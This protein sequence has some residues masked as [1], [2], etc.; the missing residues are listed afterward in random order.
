MSDT[1]TETASVTFERGYE[2]L[3]EIATRLNEDDVT[4]S[5]MCDLFAEGKGLEQALIQYLDTQQA[6]VQAIESGE[7]VRAFTITGA[8]S[9]PS[10]LQAQRSASVSKDIPVDTADF[11]PASVGAAAADDDI[12]F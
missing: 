10:A 4:V 3:Q 12:P 9:E 8:T 7:G 2:R 1:P 6:R 5:E 11:V